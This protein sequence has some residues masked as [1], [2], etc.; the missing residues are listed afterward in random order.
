MPAAPTPLSSSLLEKLLR[1]A[2]SRVLEDRCFP[3]QLQRLELF[4]SGD[5]WRREYL[6]PSFAA[7]EPLSTATSQ[8]PQPLPLFVCSSRTGSGKSLLL[9]LWCMQAHWAHV[10]QRLENTMVVVQAGSHSTCARAPSPETVLPHP[11]IKPFSTVDEG[12]FVADFKASSRLC[13]VVTQP[14]RLA[15]QEL[16][17]YTR[18]VCMYAR[19]QA[20]AAARASDGSGPLLSESAATAQA[21]AL[22]KAFAADEAKKDSTTMRRVQSDGSRSSASVSLYSRIGWCTRTDHR[23]IQPLSTEIIFT[24]QQEALRIVS[25]HAKSSAL[26]PTDPSVVSL[27]SAASPPPS[28]SPTALIIDEA[29]GRHLDSDILF[30]WAKLYRHQRCTS[31][32]PELMMRAP[33]LRLVA[34]MSATLA[35]DRIQRYFST[36]VSQPLSLTAGAAPSASVAPPPILLAP[37][38]PTGPAADE[39]DGI[40]SPTVD[41]RSAAEGW[42]HR[43][44]SPYLSYASAAKY[45]VEEMFVEHLQEHGLSQSRILANKGAQQQQPDLLHT[46]QHAASDGEPTA[47]MGDALIFSQKAVQEL[48]HLVQQV[49]GNAVVHS[50]MTHQKAKHSA[51]LLI[52]VMEIVRWR[53]S[54]AVD[55]SD[56]GDDAGEAGGGSAVLAFLPS[57]SEAQHVQTLLEIASQEEAEEDWEWAV[58]TAADR[59][60]LRRV[61]ASNLVFSIVSL[62]SAVTGVGLSQSRLLHAATHLRRKDPMKRSGV[63]QQQQYRPIRLLLASSAMESSVTLPALRMVVNFGQDRVWFT[64]SRTGTAQ[65]EPVLASADQLLQRA[66]RVGRISDGIVL[67]L[68]PLSLAMAEESAVGMLGD[69]SG[70]SRATAFPPLPVSAATVLLHVSSLFPSQMAGMLRCLPSPLDVFAMRVAVD[71]LVQQR[72]W[73]PRQ[74]QQPLEGEGADDWERYIEWQFGTCEVP[75]H[76]QGAESHLPSPAHSPP[77]FTL[78]W[79]GQLVV[80][81]PLSLPFAILLVHCV[82]FLCVEDGVLFACAASVSHLWL[83]PRSTEQQQQPSSPSSVLYGMEAH[84]TAQRRLAQHPTPAGHFSEPIRLRDLLEG[85]YRCSTPEDAT[86]FLNRHRVHRGS[87][88]MAD[89][90]IVQCCHALLPMLNPVGR[91]KG[92]AVESDGGELFFPD[93]PPPCRSLLYTSLQRLRDAA[94]VRAFSFSH[95]IP[96]STSAV[97]SR[98]GGSL[99]LLQ[100]CPPLSQRYQQLCASAHTASRAPLYFGTREERFLAAYVAAFAGFTLHGEDASHRLHR[101]MTRNKGA[102]QHLQ[103]AGNTEGCGGDSSQRKNGDMMGHAASLTLTLQ[104]MAGERE[105]LTSLGRKKPSRVASLSRA[106]SHPSSEEVDIPPQLLLDTVNSWVGKRRVVMAEVFGG[107]VPVSSASAARPAR[108][109]ALIVASPEGEE[110]GTEKQVQ[111]ES[112]RTDLYCLPVPLNPSQPSNASSAAAASPSLS[113]APLLFSTLHAAWRWLPRRVVSLPTHHQGIPEEESKRQLA[114]ASTISACV[115]SSAKWVRT[116][117]AHTLHR[118]QLQPLHLQHLFPSAD[119]SSNSPLRNK[120]PNKSSSSSR[121]TTR[122]AAAAA[123]PSSSSPPAAV[124][125]VM[126]VASGLQVEHGVGWSA[127]LPSTSV[128][129]HHLQKARQQQPPSSSSSCVDREAV[130]D[131]LFCVVCATAF[132]SPPAFAHHCL[133]SLHLSRLAS[134]VELGLDAASWRE[135]LLPTSSP[136]SSGPS[137]LLPLLCPTASALSNSFCVD[138]LVP[139]RLPLTSFLNLVQWSDTR[140]PVLAV[141]GGLR[142]TLTSG[143]G[144]SHDLPTNQLLATSEYYAERSITSL[145]P[146]HPGTRQAAVAA[147][148]YTA[149]H[150]WM[151]TATPHTSPTDSSLPIFLLAGFLAASQQKAAVAMLMTED[152]REVWGLMVRGMVWP[153]TDPVRFG[154]GDAA[155]NESSSVREEEGRQMLE[156]LRDGAVWRGVPANLSSAASPPPSS[157]HWCTLSSRSMKCSAVPSS[158]CPSCAFACAP[159]N[160]TGRDEEVHAALLVVLKEWRASDRRVIG[161]SD[162]VERVVRK[163]RIGHQQPATTEGRCVQ[164]LL[165]YLRR[166]YPACTIVDVLQLVGCRFLPPPASAV[167]GSS[168]HSSVEDSSS[169]RSNSMMVMRFVLPAVLPSRLPPVHLMSAMINDSQQQYPQ[170]SGSGTVS[171]H[172]PHSATPLF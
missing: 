14:T 86:L 171:R 85:W 44:R 24:T 117:A 27:A 155:G 132:S 140:L 31:T 114:S 65:S 126:S 95:S 119:S 94:A 162:Y 75:N 159:P 30:A 108:V 156:R 81:L 59:I 2:R 51:E 67:H 38:P 40:G 61:A 18:E 133:T 19:V 123:S 101:R 139:C 63:P 149:L 157:L 163:L 168:S 57:L 84:L 172:G 113:L 98:R 107:A 144:G 10:V 76:S 116:G 8:P 72:L 148:S 23:H 55:G 120:G 36:G 91:R 50:V 121:T 52:R 71:G 160:S 134:C 53:W 111:Q 153:F 66:G 104:P 58:P 1:G 152:H 164:D 118:S 41:W 54:E 7:P 83:P 78:T 103:L 39:A 12:S 131:G 167:W 68:V 20:A 142:A 74:V 115:P 106:E 89:Y 11:H 33:P 137:P 9:P 13:I 169:S 105:E 136:P 64:D 154:S 125:V 4:P 90:M 128:F 6:Q 124:E 138:E 109:D 80:E 15:C 130:E 100:W 77:R 28:I 49:G 99:A 60:P 35:V 47:A 82:Q 96:A 145:V 46:T 110:G 151:M 129:Y 73:A 45:R 22:M 127:L 25:E 92:L 5:A 62:S 69:P 70:G 102:V 147:S 141:A 161:L 112:E 42:K 17:R 3:Q 56:E 158:S 48:S 29:H 143:P 43:L 32:P 166:Q 16:C 87:L 170:A 93:L 79:K 37:R 165:Q 26:S 135:L 150:V 34:V 21:R 146:S 97:V 88:K 122:N